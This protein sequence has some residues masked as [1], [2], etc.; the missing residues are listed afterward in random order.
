MSLL[1]SK[2]PPTPITNAM[3]ISR[4]LFAPIQRFRIEPDFRSL[5]RSDGLVQHTTYDNR[6]A[7]E[8]RTDPGSGV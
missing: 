1:V 6:A 2:Q 3:P 4:Q 8:I 7:Y 5:A